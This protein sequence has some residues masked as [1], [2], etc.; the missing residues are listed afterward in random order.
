METGVLAFLS[1]VKKECEAYE[2]QLCI[3]KGKY[4]VLN[5]KNQCSG[6]FDP[7]EGKER[8]VVASNRKDFLSILVHEYAHLTQ[9]ADN[10]YEWYN[11][12][13]SYNLVDEWLGGE[14]VHNIGRHL[15]RAMLIELDN[16]KRSVALIKKFKL[17]ID[18]D[19]YIR[20]AN[21]YMF[22]WL[23]LKYTRSWSKASNSPYNNK[24]IISKMPKRFL[25][26]YVMT[27]RIKQLYFNEGI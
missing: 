21:S 17:P 15:K 13:E 14:D 12:G 26:E 18:I 4:V 24:T 3:R 22:F 23:Y 19:D 8:L 7:E 20:K 11:Y 27:E 9:W 16:E 5:K 6:Y 10:C 2:V 1:H 25:K